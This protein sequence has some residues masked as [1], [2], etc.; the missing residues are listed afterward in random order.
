MASLSE[1]S[2]VL[3]EA[4]G[5]TLGTI[6]F[7]GVGGLIYAF[8]EGAIAALQSAWLIMIEP[9]Q[10]LVGVEGYTG[11]VG[12]VEAIWGGWVTILEQGAQ[13]AVESLAPGSTWA[14]GPFTQLLAIGTVML[15]AFA[16]A[17]ILAQPATSN[18]APTLLVD[19]RIVTWLTGTPEE[20]E[21]DIGD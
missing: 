16:I 13:T 9:V 14:V 2:T 20:E 7:A 11:A 6:L 3:E 10:A 21:D 18:I 4:E 15:G 19:N 5:K 17:R 1:P 8:Y 12:V